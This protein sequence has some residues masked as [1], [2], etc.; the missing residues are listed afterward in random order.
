M[1]DYLVKN[2]NTLL[3]KTIFSVRSGTL[4]LKTWNKWKYEN[5]LCVMCENFDENIEHFMSCSFYGPVYLEN[6]GRGASSD[7]T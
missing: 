4:D 1:S 5:K 6:K 7:F 2:E 3:C